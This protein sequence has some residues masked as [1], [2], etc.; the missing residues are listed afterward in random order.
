MITLIAA[1]G[2]NNELGKDNQLIWRLS[3]D[4]KRFKRLTT[5]HVVIMGR[6]TYASMNKPLPNRTNIV[7]TRNPDFTAEGCIVV[8]SLEEA[9]KEAKKYDENPFIVGGGEIYRL[10]MSIADVLE[11]TYVHHT[12]EA[13]A[14]FPEIPLDQWEATFEEDH[15]ADE[16]NEYDFSFITYQKK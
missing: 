12:F 7:I 10:A 3:T 13:D 4:L 8:S 11:I 5:G 2:K 9:L 16:K 6:K 14:F 1:I 15:V